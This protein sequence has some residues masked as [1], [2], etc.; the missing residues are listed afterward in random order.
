MRYNKVLEEILFTN[1]EEQEAKE[2]KEN[3]N[4]QTT[5]TYVIIDS[6]RIKKL[7]NELIA[8]T[9]LKYE[10]LF[11]PYEQEALEEV[12]PYLIELKKEDDFTTWVYDNV[13]GKQGA[14]FIH[15]S[16]NIEE[17]AEQIRPYITTTTTVPNPNDET[18]LM[19]TEAYVR[20]Y[21]PRV[22]P[23]FY[24]S[25]ENRVSFFTEEMKILLEE[26]DDHS[27]LNVFNAKDE[28]DIKLEE[29]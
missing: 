18:E 8:L 16:Q 10:N 13:Y 19:E 21:D 6:A 20:L 22:F 5:K 24:Y 11:M 1:I 27:I 25:L 4:Y 3:S 12:A 28:K 9:S 7:T 29:G 26:M 2:K 14:I 23:D 17:L 15:S